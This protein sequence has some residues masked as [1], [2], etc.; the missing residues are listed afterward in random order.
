M[1]ALKAVIHSSHASDQAVSPAA[2]NPKRTKAGRK[3]EG[4]SCPECLGIRCEYRR[5]MAEAY[6]GKSRNG[7]E[8]KLPGAGLR[9]CTG[10][11]G[12]AWLADGALRHLRYRRALQMNSWQPIAGR[13]D[14]DPCTDRGP[15]PALEPAYPPSFRTEARRHNGQL[16][17]GCRGKLQSGRPGL[18]PRHPPPVLHPRTAHEACG[19]NRWNPLCAEKRREQ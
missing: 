3:V 9:V 2:E 17:R 6:A 18:L 13:R 16:D 1:D 5:P 15:V 7:P 10:S 11:A 4:I 8:W 12:R 14:K 19:R